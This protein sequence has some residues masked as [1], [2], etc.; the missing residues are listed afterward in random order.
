MR[1]PVNQAESQVSEDDR[2][3]DGLAWLFHT[4]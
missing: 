2:R 4:A 1:E 3:K